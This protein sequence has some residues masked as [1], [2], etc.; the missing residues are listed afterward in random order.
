MEHFIRIGEIPIDALA[1]A[2]IAHAAR[3]ADV[4]F[5]QRAPGSPHPDTETIYL[6]MPPVISRESI[7]E[8]LDVVDRPMMMEPAFRD[9]VAA[10]AHLAGDAPARAMIVK[11]KPGGRIAPHIDEGAYAAATRRFHLPIATNPLAWLDSGGERRHLPAGTLWWF[12]K[13]ALHSGGNDGAGDRIHL[14]VDTLPR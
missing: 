1:Q 13:H 10:V 6:R 7:F 14:I 3:F 2:A 12:D 8:S 5:R 11:L 4:V 9:A